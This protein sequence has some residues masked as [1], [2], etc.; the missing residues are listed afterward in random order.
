MLVAAGNSVSRCH[1]IHFL[2][3]TA[4]AHGVSQNLAKR[5]WLLSVFKQETH[6]LCKCWNNLEAVDGNR[7][8]LSMLCQFK[9]IF[10]EISEGYPLYFRWPVARERFGSG[11]G[12]YFLGRNF[13]MGFL[14]YHEVSVQHIR[15]NLPTSTICWG[16]PWKSLLHVLDKSHLDKVPRVCVGSLMNKSRQL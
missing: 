7:F 9:I 10:T 16:N 11:W 8:Y 4:V 1:R 5:W 13:V 6:M 2:Q 14:N 12:I 3:R 15:Q